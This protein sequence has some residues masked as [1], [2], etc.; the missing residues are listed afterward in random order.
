MSLNIINIEEYTF[1]KE[2]LFSWFPKLPSCQHFSQRLN[3]L[4]EAFKVTLLRILES[5]LPKDCDLDVSMVDSFPNYYLQRM[6]Q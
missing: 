2:Y 5:F 6:K 1:A 4:V 3:N